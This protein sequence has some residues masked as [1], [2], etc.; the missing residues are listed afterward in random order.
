MEVSARLRRI[1][2][3]QVTLG[4]ALLALGFLIAAQLRSEAPLVQYT[5]DERAPLVTTAQ[6]M[7]PRVRA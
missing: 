4:L 3:W 7:P 2:S 1:P 5:T 6:P